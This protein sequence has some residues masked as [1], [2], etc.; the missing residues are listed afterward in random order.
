MQNSSTQGNGR[1]DDDDN[2]NDGLLPFALLTDKADKLGLGGASSWGKYTQDT[3]RTPPPKDLLVSADSS[4][5]KRGKNK[6]KRAKLK[7]RGDK[8]NRK[9]T[10]R[11]KITA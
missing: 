9:K 7:K 6:I 10:K 4:S 8:S 1:D 5:S 11:K 3:K 2:D